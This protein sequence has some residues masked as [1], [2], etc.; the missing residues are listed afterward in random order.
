MSSV[1]RV[2]SFLAIPLVLTAC[3]QFQWLKPGATQ[4]DF[5]R[6]S[7]ECTT[8]AARTF[9]AMAVSYQITNGSTQPAYTNCS[10]V[11]N[12]VNCTTTGGGYKPGQSV[13]V[14]A[15]KNNRDNA[16]YQ[17]MLARGWTRQLIR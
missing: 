7:Y 17:C 8:E 6:D 11:G 10:G 4:Q 9:P 15:N 12:S 2:S 14:D 13:V 16:A 5:N 1:F 3:A